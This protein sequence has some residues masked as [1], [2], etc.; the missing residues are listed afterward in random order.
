MWCALCNRLLQNEQKRRNTER[1]LLMEKAAALA[2]GADFNPKR[3]YYHRGL[4]RSNHATIIA[5]AKSRQKILTMRNS[6]TLR[7]NTKTIVI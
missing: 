7:P 6:T 5:Q 3:V 1:R 2:R 4:T